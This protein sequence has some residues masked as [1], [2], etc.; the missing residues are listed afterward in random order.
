MMADP[1]LLTGFHAVTIPQPKKEVM[2]VLLGQLPAAS[3]VLVIE[4]L[5]I[6]KSFGRINNYTINPNSEL[7]AIGFTNLVGT[8]AGAYLSTGSLSRT[9]IASKAGSRTPLAGVITATLVVLALY[10]LTPVFFYVPRASLAAV[11][12]HAIG[13]LI[14]PPSTIIAYWA[15][16]PLDVVV[17]VVGLAMTIFNTI[18]H[19]VFAMVGLSLG[20][21]LWRTFR[22]QGRFLGRVEIRVADGGSNNNNSSSDPD[23]MDVNRCKDKIRS[24]TRNAF[25]SL[26]RHDG[27][28]PGI[29]I[30][31]PRP[32]IFIYRITEGFN[33][34][35]ANRQLDYLAEWIIQETKPTT[36]Q[37]FARKGVCLSL[38]LS[39]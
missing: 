38:K 30:E 24:G 7:I 2:Q 34:T 16:S 14:T 4:H 12:I 27:S 17:F 28:N 19:G 37:L 13:D 1:P 32:G 11:I 23:M 21:H 18:D 29:E 25:I 33:Y 15:T 26:D 5:S 8:F 20:I 39:L 10:T 6:A 9:A 3:L 22:A 35:N 36:V 31:K